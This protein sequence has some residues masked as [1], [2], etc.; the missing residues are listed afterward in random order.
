MQSGVIGQTSW[1]RSILIHNPNI[2]IAGGEGLIADP[3]ITRPAEAAPSIMI[4]GSGGDLTGATCLTIWRNPDLRICFP[5]DRNQSARVCGQTETEGA[6][7][8]QIIDNPAR[9]ATRIR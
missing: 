5:L 4:A 7:A 9:R 2:I 1:S 8:A 3:A 6:I